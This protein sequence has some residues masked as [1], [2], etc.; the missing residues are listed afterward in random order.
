MQRPVLE[1]VEQ[2]MH[3]FMGDSV[4][5]GAN[6]PANKWMMLNIASRIEC[7]AGQ[8]RNLFA[9]ASPTKVDQCS[10]DMKDPANAFSFL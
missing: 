7:D 4:N 1:A 10:A 9:C 5:E 8:A 6:V 2:S 3:A